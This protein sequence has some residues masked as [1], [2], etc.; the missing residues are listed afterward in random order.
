MTRTQ[1]FTLEAPLCAIEAGTA[2]TTTVCPKCGRGQRVQHQD[3]D[4]SLVCGPRAVWLSDG[5]AILVSQEVASSI[6]SVAVAEVR[7]RQTQTSWR[8]GVDWAHQSAPQL[9]QIVPE[10]GVSVS[11]NNIEPSGCSCGAI[12]AIAFNPLS[13]VWPG[14]YASLYCLRENP[15]IVIFDERIKNLLSTYDDDL[16]FD[17]VYWDDIP[18]P[19]DRRSDPFDWS[20]I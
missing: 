12:R 13:V 10:S 17:D 16:E 8:E 7:F 6:S 1:Y 11:P 18:L 14:Q 20:D 19:S 3:L 2:R 9:V 15:E 4:V 5:S